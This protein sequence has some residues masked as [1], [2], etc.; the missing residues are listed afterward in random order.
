MTDKR[1]YH[2]AYTTKFKANVVER[3]L[4]DKKI[5][6]I[7]DQTYFYPTSGGQPA[8]RG[9]LSGEPVVDV[10]I[11]EDDG[12][13][14]HLVEN[15]IW[16]DEVV[17][18]VD[19]ERRFDHM[20]Q[21]TG[22]HILSQA[23]I[24]VAEA[25]TVGFHL[26]EN[27]VTIDLQTSALEPADVTRAE[28]LANQVIWKD[29]PVE[30]RM[31]SHQRARK[32]PL[33]KLPDLNGEKVRLIEI[34]DFDL[35][36][37]GGTHVARTGAIG[38]IKVIG[39]ERRGEQLRVEFRCGGR[40][41]RDYRKKNSII[42]RL[43][44]QFTTGYWELEDKIDSLREEAKEARR[45]LSKRQTALLALT[46]EELLA[47]AIR[48]GQNKII[49]RTFTDIEPEELRVLAKH[50]IQ[51]PS[52]VA[53]LG[54]AGEKSQLVFARTEDAPGEMNQLLK[55]ALH[56]LG[57]TAG[58]GSKTFAQGGGF[59]ADKE[60]MQHALAR[61]KDLLLSQVRERL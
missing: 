5:A 41:L 31:V 7:L 45:L 40:A 17:G 52:V 39:L 16:T 44:S 35:T 58:G 51:Q 1:Y 28:L 11:R 54:L 53:L 18:T 48:A 36:A 27:S 49:A 13:V 43:A 20:Q 19:W 22:Q 10:F 57:T 33:R 29:R 61:T 25:P 34:K 46:A 38:M 3:F 32:L 8:D 21:H 47:N 9:R 60:R 42:N 14:V 23:F 4:H 12:A 59:P 15:E 37:C 56:V 55:Q 2:D 50:L 24:R 26:S 30:V 6:L